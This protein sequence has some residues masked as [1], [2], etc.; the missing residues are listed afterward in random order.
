MDSSLF[1]PVLAFFDFGAAFPSVLHQ[2]L[3]L[4]FYSIGLPQGAINIG[5]SMYW[6]VMGFGS[7]HQGVSAFLFMIWSGVLQGC[8]LSGTFFVFAIDP[9]LQAFEAAIVHADR[10]VVAA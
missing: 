9:F 3:M 1:L 5:W 8:P 4:V 7:S 10:G 2:W 6:M